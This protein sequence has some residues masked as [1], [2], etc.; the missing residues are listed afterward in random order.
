VEVEGVGLER[1][2]RIAAYL[3]EEGLTQRHTD[4]E[5]KGDTD[6]TKDAPKA[7]ATPDAGSDPTVSGEALRRGGPPPPQEPP[8]SPA[9]QGTA[10]DPSGSLAD[11]KVVRT[12]GKLVFPVFC[13]SCEVVLGVPVDATPGAMTAG[14]VGPGWSLRFRDGTLAGD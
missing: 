3:P 13:A 11:I 1:V 10:P 14:C 12:D 6:R 8:E 9:A 2:T 4:T 5:Q 7:S